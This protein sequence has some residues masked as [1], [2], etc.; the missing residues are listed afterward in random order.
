MSARIVVVDDDSDCVAFLK[1]ILK[2]RGYDV[3]V[4]FDGEEGLR[5][6]RSTLP[7]LVILDLLMPKVSGVEV[8][9]RM[10]EDPQ[11]RDL[12]IIVLSIIGEKTGKP[13][14]FWRTGLGAD[15]FIHKTDPLN[16]LA[17][18]GRIEYVLRRKEYVS[19]QEEVAAKGEG[20]AR[21]PQPSLQNATPREVVRCF[22]EAWNSQNFGDEY[23]CLTDLMRGSIEEPE[24]V[25]RR[26]Q[27]HAEEGGSP[28]RQR[29]ASVIEETL[30][31]DTA[32]ILVEREDI[33]DTRKNRRREQYSL[34]RALD[35]WKITTVR[36]LPKQN[37]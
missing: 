17:L 6:I 24:Y 4:A 10:R 14:E 16:P 26:Q 29:L 19:S 11:T 23:N 37:H 34:S 8:I 12:P 32:R 30:N 22:I 20:A 28:H 3:A 35:G 1:T 2:S 5:L 13:E 31:G 27:A 7:D 15:D 33:Y 9:R 36:V 18:I 21:V 25:L